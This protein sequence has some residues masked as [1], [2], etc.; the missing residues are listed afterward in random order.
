MQCIN[1]KILH[2]FKWQ[3][4]SLIVKPVLGP[5]TVFHILLLSVK[6]LIQAETAVFTLPL[7]FLLRNDHITSIHL[8]LFT[9]GFGFSRSNYIWLCLIIAAHVYVLSLSIACVWIVFSEKKSL[10]YSLVV[11][12]MRSPYKCN[13]I[14]T[15]R[16]LFVDEIL[17]CFSIIARCFAYE[18][19]LFLEIRFNLFSGDLFLVQQQSCFEK[20]ADIL[21]TP[22]HIIF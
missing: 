9:Q 16:D 17:H 12:S 2:F 13:T 7:H 1:K 18:N 4:L 19:G 14:I 10:F 20:I 11:V 3:C 6:R 5:L 21:C 22:H 15:F 8:N